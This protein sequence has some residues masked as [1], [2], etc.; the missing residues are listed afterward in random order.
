M[1]GGGL[2]IARCVRDNSSGEI[3][4]SVGKDFAG[5]D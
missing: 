2:G 4:H 3:R 1:R 5:M